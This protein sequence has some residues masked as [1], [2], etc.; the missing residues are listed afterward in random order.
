MDEIKSKR[1]IAFTSLSLKQ[2]GIRAVRM[3]AIAQNMNVSKRT[4]YQIYEKKDNLINTC[5]E[6]YS[7]RTTNLFQIIQYNNPN[8]LIYLW[9]ISKAY[10]E[11]L[12]K[13]K[14]VFWFDITKY[15]QYI[16]TAIENIWSEE[17]ERAISMCQAEHYVIAD[18]NIKTFLE[19]F[20]TL[21][22]NARIAECSSEI[23]YNSAYFTLRGI[24]TGY[25]TERFDQI[26][27]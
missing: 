12:Y 10:I 20:T 26:R 14:C 17:L 21:L 9:E 3:D 27:I 2:Y 7:N 22:Y 6:S 15:Y 8:S 25:G 13:A 18:L 23:L 1:I 4:I 16:Y 11:N 5:L 24:M 19:S